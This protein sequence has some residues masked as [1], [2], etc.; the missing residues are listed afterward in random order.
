LGDA[1]HVAIWH[2]DG[3][4]VVDPACANWFAAQIPN[5]LL[6]ILPDEGHISI[7]LQLPTIIDDLLI[8]A[9]WTES[10]DEPHTS[11]HPT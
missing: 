6:R 4:D 7:G 8:R 9:G 5:A 2:G 3:D 10:A 1:Q 11:P